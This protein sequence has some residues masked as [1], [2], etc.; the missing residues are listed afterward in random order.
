MLAIK[1]DRTNLR[2]TAVRDRMLD[3]DYGRIVCIASIAGFRARG[4]VITYSTSRVGVIAFARSSQKL[5][6][7]RS[8]LIAWHHV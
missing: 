3:W 6:T 2:V 8:A 4:R 5:S 1:L 7:R